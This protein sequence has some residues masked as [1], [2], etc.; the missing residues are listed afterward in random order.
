MRHRS[1]Y[2]YFD[3]R[4]GC[5]VARTTVTNDGNRRNLKRHAASKSEA[6]VQLKALVRQVDD[7]GKQVADNN[8]VTFNA[9]ADYY[10]KHYLKAAQYVSGQKVSGLR[11]LARPKELLKHFRSFFGK[12]KL[13]EITYGDLLTYRDRRFKVLTQY[14]KQ[15][16]ISSWN[17]EAAV[18]RRIF[19]I[20]RQQGWLVKNPFHCGDPLIIVSAERRRERILTLEE[21][22]RL[23]EACDH[24]QRRHLRPLLICLLDTGARKSEMLKLHWRAVCFATRI[25]TIE[26]M[27]TKTL[28]T[29][30]VAMTERM[31]RELAALS[32]ESPKGPDSQVFGISDNV[33]NSFK[34]ACKLAGIK[35]GG[36]DGL[37]IHSLRHTAATR[38]VK[39]HLPLEMVGRILGHSQPQTTYRYL[40]ANVETA[41]Q[42]ASILDALQRGDAVSLMD[43]VSVN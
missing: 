11:A 4:K 37:T 12:K 42:A 32:E 2:V 6:E 30:R 31:Y 14:K 24:P 1:G 3:E 28:K 27:T 39:G 19:N 18:L 17:R 36:L 25:I 8:L 34:S 10:E 40:T 5:W 16:T 26:G 29:R 41:F 7:E 9:L 21:E 35:C 38:L 43:C 13:R 33:R 20:A 23:L 15:R 22:A